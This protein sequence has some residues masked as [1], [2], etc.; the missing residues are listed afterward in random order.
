MAWNIFIEVSV[1]ILI[2]CIGFVVWLARLEGRVA[3]QKELFGV[4]LKDISISEAKREKKA[5]SDET[6]KEHTAEILSTKL[7]IITEKLTRLEERVVRFQEEL[8]LG[9]RR[10]P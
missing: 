4:L 3:F 5:I 6:K 1:A 7:E 10:K 8:K 9:R 2:P